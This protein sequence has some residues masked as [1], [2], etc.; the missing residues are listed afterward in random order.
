MGPGEINTEIYVKME[1]DF[2]IVSPHFNLSQITGCKLN[3]I[4]GQVIELSKS[5]QTLGE[6]NKTRGNMMCRKEEGVENVTKYKG[7]YRVDYAVPLIPL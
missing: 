1:D 6:Q 3:S 7:G 5:C 4:L 2:F